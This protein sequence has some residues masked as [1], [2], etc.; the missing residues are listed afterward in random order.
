MQSVELLKL[1]EQT[2]RI[3]PTSPQLNPQYS[4]AGETACDWIS[5][6]VSVS[7]GTGAPLN[8][9]IWRTPGTK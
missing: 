9:S 6:K 3:I 5:N 2:E 1:S 8:L 7:S 4:A